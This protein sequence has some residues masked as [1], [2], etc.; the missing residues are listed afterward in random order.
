MYNEFFHAAVDSYMRKRATRELE[1]PKERIFTH[2]TDRFLREGFVRV[3]MDE[4]ASDLIMSKRTLYSV[5]PSKKSIVREVIDHLLADIRAGLEEI[6]NS[7]GTFIVT[8]HRTMTFL[9]H[10]GSRIGKPFLSDLQ[11]QMPHQWK[12]IQEFRRDRILQTFS[13][14][15][16]QGMREGY[17]R[18]GINKEVF[19]QSYLAAVEAIVT[20][21]VL[22]YQS[23]S[24]GEAIQNILEIFF[25]GV[26]TEDATRELARFQKSTTISQHEDL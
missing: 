18:K 9:A 6:R 22:M 8:F 15:L 3:S 11:R 7:E 5:F 20:P 23:Y 17:I 25:R 4:I 10:L 12:R 14:L 21:S 19:L 2:V 13:N 16:D 1:N 26:L 24:A